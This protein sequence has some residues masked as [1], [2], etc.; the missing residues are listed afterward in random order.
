MRRCQENAYLRKIWMTMKL[1]M[2]LFFLAITNLMASEAYSQ[3][4]KLSLQLKDATVKEVLN[5][6]EDNSDYFFL[7][8]SKLVDVDRKVSMD[9]NDEK[10]N[11]ILEDLFRG[12]NVVYAVV[13][14]QIVLTDKASRNSF[15]QLGGQQLHK[16]TGKV[17]NTSGE[18]LP[19]VSVVVKGTTIG[20]I[21]DINGIYSISDIPENSIL[22]FSFVGMKTQESNVENKE[23]ID[24]VLVENAVG[25]EEV[26]VVG[27][28]TQKK[29]SLTGSITSVK[30]E[31]ITRSPSIGVS[32]SLAGL[33]PGVVALNRSGEPGNDNS[34]ILIRGMSTTGTTSPLVVVDGIQGY[35]GWE[36]INSDD[37]ESISILKDASAAIYGAR[38]ANGVILITTKR[39]TAGKPTISYSFSQGISKPTRVPKMASSALF[40]E[41]V[42]D[43]QVMNGGTPKYTDAE[44]QKFRDGSDPINYPNTDWYGEVLKKFSLQSQH[45][46]KLQGGTESLKY[47]V[48][49]S[50]SNQDGIFKNGSTNFKTY[51]LL[52]RFDGQIN[53]N[54]KVGFDMNA[55]MDDGNYPGYS[56]STLFN[57]L[58]INLPTEPVFWPNGFPSAGVSEGCN[59]AVMATDATG[60]R[61][62]R[63]QHYTGKAS[64]DLNIPWVKG[65][66]VD[67]YFSYSNNTTLVKNW[68]R[69]WDTYSYNKT[70]DAYVLVKGGGIKNPQLTESTLN[71]RGTLINLRVKYEKR[72]EDH[73]INAF[74]AVEQSDYK[75]N[76]FSAFRKDFLSASLPELFAGS[77]TGMTANGSS[78]ENGRKNLFGRLSYD[79]QGKYLADFNFRYDGSSNFPKE[80]RWGFFP[81]GSLGWRIS[82]EN[83]I[84][85]NFSFINNLKL[86]ASYGQIGNDQISAFQWLSTYTLGTT[87]YTF[88]ISPVTAQG[89]V[90]GVTPNKNITWEVAEITNFGLDAELWKGLLGFTIDVFKQRRSHILATRDLSVP[91]F[92]GLTLPSEN[93]GVVENKGIEVEVSH[94][95]VINDFSYRVGANVAYAKNEVI[96]IS[97]AVNVPEWQKAEGHVIGATKYYEAIGIFRTQDEVNSNPVMAGTK[98]GDLQYEDVDND[99][100]I[101]DADMVTL[102]KTNTPQVTFGLNVSMTYKSFSLWANFTGQTKAWQYFHKYSK[103]G[104]YNA[105][106]ELLENRYKTGSMDSKYPIIPSSET[107][108]MDVSGFRSTFWLKDASFLRLK[109]LELSYTLPENLLAKANISGMRVFINGNNLFTL[110]KLKWYD[111]EGN[112]TSGNFYPQSKIFNIGVNV[113]F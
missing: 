32:N 73:H 87:G 19:G 76:D 15:S 75:N 9:A 50:Y 16:V 33:L 92:T 109:T 104:G 63:V 47:L 20:T 74:I 22:Q 52:G 90:A 48:S 55:A 42:N 8:N 60:N 44:I 4:T 40:A 21:T 53:K 25:L 37:I 105:L 30:N 14:K 108:T 12:T 93:V 102:D 81:G 26:V 96:D 89:L 27:Y 97:E 38:A 31:E 70:T 46:I 71:N 69:P 82:E 6:I 106:E 113:S 95:K 107:E 77:L 72:I 112:S 35:S 28:G 100:K 5:K 67:G 3:T 94:A 18:L 61:N 84:K 43:R 49:G 41:F 110:D 29:A 65:L 103:E 59:P 1:T 80:G 86:R 79:F 111:P 101:T 51:S 10:I 57:Y 83:F 39:G 11:K 68:Q 88:G 54:L 36:R 13:D 64:F 45:N 58:G 2:V 56:T 7:Y 78:S 98:V 34:S 23:I 99:G 62:Q 85:N 66:G 91:Y 17:T 24:I